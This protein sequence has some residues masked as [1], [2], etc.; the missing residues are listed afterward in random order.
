MSTPDPRTLLG[1]RYFEHG[2]VL[3]HFHDE[4]ITLDFGCGRSPLTKKLAGRCRRVIGVDLIETR[5]PALSNLTMIKANI[6]RVEFP[7]NHFDVIVNC[8]TIEHVGISG[9]YGITQDALNDDLSVMK[10]FRG[11]L[12]PNGKMLLTLPVGQDRLVSPYHRIYGER[13]GRLLRGWKVIA[14]AFFI[15][16]NSD[17]YK[18]TSSERAIR[19]IST[20]RYYALGLFVLRISEGQMDELY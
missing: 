5:Q 10:L 1:D 12:K 6:L 19:D 18:L 4:G 3:H 9:R 20:E 13:L 7:H 8:S 11:I 17:Q 14:S 15:K 16:T 2:W